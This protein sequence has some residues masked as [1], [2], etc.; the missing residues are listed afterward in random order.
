MNYIETLAAARRLHAAG[1]REQ[2]EA[3]YLRLLEAGSAEL[4]AAL[5]ADVMHGLAVLAYE[6]ED[7]VQAR[8]WAEKALELQASPACLNTLGLIGLAEQ[9][10]LEARNFF[11]QA[12]A[13]APQD[14]DVLQNLG[15][16]HQL[17]GH[18][19]EAARYY[20]QSLQLDP[21]RAELMVSLGDVLF[22]IGRRTEALDVYFQAVNLRP[23]LVQ[24]WQ[25]FGSALVSCGRV[26]DAIGCFQHALQLNPE[27]PMAFLG[28]AQAFQ[29]GG[30]LPMAFKACQEALNIYP[31]LAPAYARLGDVLLRAGELVA[32]EQCAREALGIKPEDA[33][34]LG[35]LGHVL[36]LRGEQAEARLTLERALTC[37]PVASHAEIYINLFFCLRN[38]PGLSPAERLAAF[39]DWDAKVGIRADAL[40]PLPTVR[41]PQ[42]RLR[43]G[44]VSGDLLEHSASVVSE[45]LFRHHDSDSFD[46]YVYAK[47][48]KAD[49]RT[50]LLKQLAARWD[51][52]GYSHWRDIAALSESETLDLIRTDA[53]DLLVD[54]NGCTENNILP[55]FARRPAQIQFTGLGYG[56]TT[57]L[58]AIDYLFTDTWL[59]APELAP[60]VAERLLYLPQLMNWIPPAYELAADISPLTEGALTLGCANSLFKLNPTVL[61]CWR[62]ILQALPEARLLLKSPQFTDAALSAD[63]TRKL[64]EMGFAEERFELLGP[65]PREEHLK[66]FQQLDLVL[67]PFPYN[68]GISSLEALWMGRPLV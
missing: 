10:M 48:R 43:V 8:H 35:L 15:L 49:A 34:Y 2:A 55:V 20:L 36:L 57:G 63:F 61:A 31:R 28:L 66:F 56:D 19:Q 68:G 22:R 42:R 7:W 9:K 18:W 62:D 12:Q 38:L 6:I 21:E 4:G 59:F 58:E 40:A 3:A 37:E 1:E 41:D 46:I 64:L 13:L 26:D 5:E 33:S 17:Q 60:Q 39:K 11:L 44:Y 50:G 51:S 52:D 45:L 24:A 47:A 14:A 16:W 29:V 23:D 54:M 25:N 67:D 65:S 27:D 32:A 53:I 30:Q